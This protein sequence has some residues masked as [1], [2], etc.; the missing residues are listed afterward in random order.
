MDA[1]VSVTR[2]WG[3]GREGGLLVRNRADMRRFVS[4][5][6]GCTVLMGRVTYESFPKGPLRGRRNVVVSR[7][8]HYVPPKV[9]PELPRG[10]SVVVAHSTDEALAL[11][12]DDP[13]VWLIGGSSLYRELLPRCERC[14]VTKNEVIVPGTDAFFPNLDA[15]AAWRVESEE[16]GG[17]T[18]EGIAYTFLTYAKR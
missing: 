13:Q 10:T 7:N 16:P 14:H 17:T 3:I 4:L 18:E 1:I 2:D 6:Q 15:D 9:P 11:T 5:T 12:Q 8:M